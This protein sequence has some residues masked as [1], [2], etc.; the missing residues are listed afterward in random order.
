MATVAIVAEVQKR[1]RKRPRLAWD[2]AP[3]E[4]EARPPSPPWRGDDKDGHYLFDIGDNLTPRY[5]ILS[6][7]GEGTFGRV[8]ECYDLE[9]RALV[10]IKVIRSTKKYREAALI[11]IDI[12]HH[13]ARNDAGG[14]HC[15]QIQ[16]WF[17]YRNHI[18]IVCERL[19]PSLF[20]FLKRNKYRPF[21]VD[22]VREFGRQ[23]LESVAYMHDLRLI[24][25]DLKPENILLVSSEYVKLPDHRRSSQDEMYFR[26]LPKSSSIKLIDFGSTV[27]ESLNNSSVVSTRHYRAPEVILGLGWTFP[28]DIWSIGCILT[29]LCSGEALFQ[30]HENL[31]HLAMMERVLGPLPEHMIRKADRCAEKYFRRGTHLNWPEGAGSRES[32]RAVRKLDRLKSIISSHVHSSSATLVDLLYGLLKFDPTQRLTA[33]EALNHPFF[34]R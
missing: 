16:N 28:C 31:E 27:F 9:T 17:D 29:E 21:P 6:K 15:V 26:C 23:L 5:K 2:V 1:P 32:I 12:L 25:T 24:H 33:R 18:C 22:L 34:S 14:S 10:A 30:T 7:M 13:L 8:L 11:E 20:D 3:I 19:G 4:P